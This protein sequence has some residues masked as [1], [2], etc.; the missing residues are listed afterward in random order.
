MR[1]LATLASLAAITAVAGSASAVTRDEVMTRALSYASHPW[2][3]TSANQTATCSA[4]YKSL[5]PPGDYVGVA[6]NWGGYQSLFEYDKNLVA[7]F[8]AGAQE[9][10]G[11]LSCT[12]GVDCSGFVSKTWDAGHFT[13]SDLATTSGSIAAAALLP[14]D[15]FNK[16]GY[17]VT[18]FTSSLASGAPSMV[19]AVGYNV[20]TNVTGGWSYVKGFTPLRYNAI[21]GTMVAPPVGTPSAPILINSFPYSDSR[22]TANS[23]S[24]TLGGCGL[25]PNTS[26][27]GPEYVYQTT[28]TQPGT[29]DVSVTYDAGVDVDVELFAPLTTFA[30]TARGDTAFSKQVGCGTYSIVADTFASKSKA[31]NYTLHASFTPSGQPCSAVPGPS[32]NPKGKLGDACAYPGHPNLP[33]CNENLGGSDTCIYGSGGS[34]CSKAC[35]TDPDCAGMPGGG[36]CQDISGKG[37]FY[38]QAGASCPGSS[39]SGTSGTSGTSGASGTSGGTSGASGGTSG[40]SGEDPGSA[41]GPGGATTTETSGCST[42][43]SASTAWPLLLGVFAAFAMTRRRRPS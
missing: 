27:A 23:T 9:T 37:E 30:C 6:Y 34:Y 35:A 19:E 11:V 40:T 15:V 17:H 3:S 7:G 18:M 26:E 42:T 43:A 38:C 41:A 39:S 1:P 20:H 8:G 2:T 36:C 4:A 5:D 24:V 14:G 28:F 12:A 33:Y 16:A 25:A 13:T 22:N 21:T 31:G 32:F 10:D 29:L